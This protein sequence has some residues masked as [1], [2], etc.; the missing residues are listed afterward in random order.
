MEPKPNEKRIR[1]L[2]VFIRLVFPSQ[3]IKVTYYTFHN[4]L[5]A[6]IL[7]IIVSYNEN[8][9][10]VGIKAITES[11]NHYSGNETFTKYFAPP[12]IAADNSNSS[13]ITRVNSDRS[14]KYP[15]ERRD[16]FID[17]R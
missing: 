12:K 7:H 8:Q 16:G 3:V 17:C 11:F 6:M 2:Y 15:S 4:I 14:L 10:H 13:P 5:Y 9:A 1:F